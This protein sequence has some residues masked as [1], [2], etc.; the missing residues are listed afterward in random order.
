M[1]TEIYKIISAIISTL[2]LTFFISVTGD[3]NINEKKKPWIS[4]KLFCIRDYLTVLF[5]IQFSELCLS[6]NLLVLNKV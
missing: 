4:S 2:F 5:L 6:E 3:K 1:I